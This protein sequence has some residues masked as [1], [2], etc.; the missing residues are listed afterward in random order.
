M[1]RIE[2][3]QAD[4]KDI[5]DAMDDPSLSDKH[6]TK[7]LV[8]RMHSE[9]GKHGF[10]AKC[11][12][13]HANTITNYL[14][15]WSDGGLA[16]VVEDKYYKPSSTIEPFMA[17]LRCSFAATPVA[18]AK[19][20]IARIEALT[21][22]KLSESQAR[23]TLHK[24]GMK[25]RKTA[26]I[27]GKCDAQLQFDFYQQEMLPRLGQAGRGERKVFFVDA[28]HFVM[29][30]FLGMLWCFSRIFIKTSP[31]RQRYSVLG[32]IDSH[33]HEIISV[34]TDGT[35]SASLVTEL[36]DKIRAAHPSTP[37]TL[38]LDN[39][40]YQRCKEVAIHAAQR[41][42]ELLYLPAY[43]PNLNLIERL[44]KLTKKKCLTNKH[45]QNFKDFRAAI[46]DCL[47]RMAGE[48]L[49]ELKSLITL[50]FEFFTSH[51]TS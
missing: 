4:I 10:I 34:T 1:T 26:A 11:L 33:S 35:V 51:K 7:L 21:G 8:I 48:Y 46:D 2:L 19:A 29:G 43:S 50:N 12:K 42:I 41:D 27:P 49:P 28:A 23:R 13:L 18:D 22:I 15:E 3:S 47:N 45:Y 25:Y 16:A 36:L 31:G 40:R 5:E 6:R 38:V 24:L 17:C 30:A 39:A 32:A 9:G 37:V 44:W 14:K 20:A